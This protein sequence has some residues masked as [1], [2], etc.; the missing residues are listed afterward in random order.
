MMIA[1]YPGSFDPM[2]NG[3]LDLIE[4]AASVF[5]EVIV[6]IAPNVGKEPLFTVE[7]RREMLSEVCRGLRNVSVDSFDGLLVSYV[8]KKNARVIVKGLRAVSDFQYEF[9]M[10]LTNRRLAPSVE[11][12]FLMTSADYSYLSSSLVKEIAA[13]GGSVQGLAPESVEEK[14]KQRLQEAVRRDT[15]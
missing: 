12:V 11:T 1:V 13:L 4:R 3:H 6:A 5:D 15:P 14:L 9:E 8:Q 2:T 7:E 10:A